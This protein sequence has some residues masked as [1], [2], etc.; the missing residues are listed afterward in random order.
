MKHAGVVFS[1][2]VYQM[3]PFEYK[4]ERVNLGPIG[5]EY[6]LLFANISDTYKK[7]AV[8]MVNF[9][10]S[11]TAV[12][13]GSHVKEYGLCNFSYFRGK[14]LKRKVPNI[15]STVKIRGN[16]YRYKACIE[17]P[18]I[19]VGRGDHPL[20]GTIKLAVTKADVVINTSLH[21]TYIGSGWND[22]VNIDAPWVARYKDTLSG[23]YKYV[24]IEGSIRSTNDTNKF[25]TARKLAKRLRGTRIKNNA[26]LTSVH[27]KQME[28]STCVCIIDT[29]CLR[30]GNE[31][32]PTES[33][34]TVGCCSL[35]VKHV[36]TNKGRVRLTFNGKDSIQ[37]DKTVKNEILCKNMQVLCE[38]KKKDDNVFTVTPNRVNRYIDSIVSG[39]TLKCFRT[40]HASLSM[41]KSL[42]SCQTLID[43]RRANDTVACMLCHKSNGRALLETSKSNYIDPRVIF[44]WCKKVNIPFDKVYTPRL[45]EKHKWACSVPST[46]VYP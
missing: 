29:M 40:C 46:F 8:F 32:D 33:A 21:S 17:P 36:R 30:A 25:E 23:E 20:R 45:I 18:S 1:K 14:E 6:A 38:G 34:D 12:I 5:E 26:N 3:I 7:D 19:F 44:S 16:V 4:G 11:W 43:F 2:Y 22:V 9:M 28:C 42:L 41:Y 37:W 27:R 35:Q 39:V 10:K 31:K 13:R 24:M 15:D